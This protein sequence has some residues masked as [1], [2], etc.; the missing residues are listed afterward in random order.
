M[1]FSRGSGG[2]DGGPCDLRTFS[3]TRPLFLSTQKKKK[4]DLLAS[5]RESGGSETGFPHPPPPFFSLSPF[6]FDSVFCFSSSKK[7]VFLLLTFQRVGKKVGGQKGNRNREHVL[8]S[9]EKTE[10]KSEQDLK[11]VPAGKKKPL[12]LAEWSWFCFVF[13]SSACFLSL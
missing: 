7:K 12:L 9:T 3:S 13:C 10:K 8:D 1:S 6:S 11:I 2:A 5:F 4:N